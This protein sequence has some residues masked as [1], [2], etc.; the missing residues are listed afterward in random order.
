MT[1]TLTVGFL[2][3]PG[4]TLLDF[5]GATQIFAYT[6]GFRT[7]WIAATTDPVA[8]TEGVSVVP[9]VSF[10]DAPQP[11]IVFV[12]GGGGDGVAAA[13]ADP[14]LQAWLKQA[15][16]QATWAGSV[17]TGAFVVA[18]AGLFDGCAVTTY[19]SARDALALFPSLEV[20]PGYPRA[21]IDDEHRRF[22][23]GGIS[24]SLDLALELVQ[25][26]AG[27]RAAQSAQLDNQY[28][29]DPPVHSGDPTQAAP[30][31]VISLTQQQASMNAQLVAAVQALTGG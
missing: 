22:S 28:A 25:E 11:D 31:L 10:A 17:C 9:N 14:A 23:G 26:I 8:T 6:P 1:T 27:E 2:L 20:V 12:P 29:P 18:A 19:W 5:A 30:E 24:S 15:G 16:A 4:C 21:Q 3:Y 13:M 7:V